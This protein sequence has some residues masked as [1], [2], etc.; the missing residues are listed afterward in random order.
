MT[1]DAL[2]P[3]DAPQTGPGISYCIANHARMFDFELRIPGQ[4]PI[5]GCI[6]AVDQ[7]D[8][9]RILF[10]RHPQASSI[11]IGKGR[12]IIPSAKKT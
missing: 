1:I 9:E 10:N 2:S 6:R 12:S 5:R 11:D 4:R 7:K 3:D 8:A